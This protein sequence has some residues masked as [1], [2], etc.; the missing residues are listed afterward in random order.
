MKP[1][2]GQGS[3]LRVAPPVQSDTGQNYYM[4][5]AR[6]VRHG[7]RVITIVY[8][9]ASRV[10]WPSPMQYLGAWL[11]WERFAVQYLGAKLAWEWD[12]DPERCRRW[13][14]RC[15]GGGGGGG[16]VGCCG[17]LPVIMQRQ[18][19]QS[20]TESAMTSGWC[21]SSVHRQCGRCSRWRASCASL[22]CEQ[23][24]VPTVL[25]SSWLW[26]VQYIDKVVDVGT[27]LLYG[28]L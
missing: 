16:A 8:I 14:G 13:W 17:R 9:K 11:A 6:A 18:V 20:C 1:G 15:G 3:P 26:L 21:L 5:G 10:L 22:C 4:P 24:Q 27:W 12:C 7:C 28:G 23:R 19:L 25:F 2:A